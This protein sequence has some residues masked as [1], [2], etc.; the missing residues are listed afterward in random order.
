MADRENPCADCAEA[1]ELDQIAIVAIPGAP[2][3]FSLTPA[4][5]GVITCE[6]H[7]RRVALA[8]ELLAAMEATLAAE[9]PGL[10]DVSYR[11]RVIVEPVRRAP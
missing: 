2:A 5:A 8:L 9:L 7:L 10:V 4:E 6:R 3:P 11:D 1:I